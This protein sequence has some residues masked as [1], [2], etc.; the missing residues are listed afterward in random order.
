VPSKAD[1]ARCIDHTLLAPEA[2]PEQIDRLCDEAIE[3]GFH[4]V[5]VNPLYVKRT[6]D[7]LARLQ[8]PS[9]P[10]VVSVA[11]FPL[12]ATSTA[13][14]AEEARRAMGDGAGEIDMVMLIG[15]LIARD[16]K[17]VRAD[18]EALCHAVHQSNPPGL[19]KVIL[20]TAVLNETQ[21]VQACRACAEA[22]ADFVKTSTGFHPAG[23]A[24]VEHVR[25]LHRYAT[26]MKVKASG[27]IRDAATAIAMLN[28]G[29]ARLGCSS[30]LDILSQ[31]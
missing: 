4:A 31:L 6:A 16:Y 29:A 18:I 1:V 12:G 19:L 8:A 11:G 30:S 23:G 26:P 22:Q 17:T 14:K 28:A 5:C 21:I 25:L 9:K 15:A 27:G 13:V 7:R 20:E 24:T 10:I 3:H 2:T